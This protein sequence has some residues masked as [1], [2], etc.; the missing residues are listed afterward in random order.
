MYECPNCGG[1]LRFDIAS[2]Q[3]ACA[4]CDAKYDPYVITKDRDAEESRDFEVT[5]FTC[6]QC[7]GE[8]YSTDNTAAG[9]CSFCGASTILDSRL[10]RQKRPG[11]IIPFKKTKA[12]CKR[13][14]AKIVK[15]A[16]FAPK[17]LRDEK[18]IDSFRGIYMPYWV[19][20]ITQKGPFHMTG[21][22]SHQSGDYYITDYYNISGKL[23]TYYKGLYYDASSSFADNISERI[24]PFDV[25]NMRG[26]TPSILSGF[27]ADTADVDQALYKEDA[28]EKANGQTKKYIDRSKEMKGYSLDKYSDLSSKY[29]TRCESADIAMF[30]VWFLSYR[31]KDRVAYATVNGQTG[32]VVADLP[33]DIKK[34]MGGSFLLAVIIFL[35]LN[36]FATFR[37]STTLMF[38]AGIAVMALILHKIEMKQ[39]IEKEQYLD[40]KGAMNAL[41]RR[42]EKEQD[43]QQAEVAGT[44]DEYTYWNNA[45]KSKTNQKIQAGQKSPKKKS[46]SS[47]V[48]TVIMIAIVVDAI[49]NL[50][51]VSVA[52]GGTGNVLGGIVVLPVGI[53]AGVINFVGYQRMEGMSKVPGFLGAFISVL[54]ACVV[55]IWNPVSDLYYYAGAIISLVAVFFTLVNLIR[56]YNILATRKLPQFDYQGGDDRA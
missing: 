46:T 7:A 41:Q 3:L 26:F 53:V 28:I 5:V 44:T 16:I 24:A 34:Y 9:F 35:L 39:I 50:L 49:F 42:T 18:H 8:I 22:M 14:Y 38:V 29:H 56:S 48:L 19:Y 55:L 32:K 25:K 20:Y 4:H 15:K 21:T 36:L 10:T 17:E 37:P 40:D 47:K 33:V 52:A 45:Q 2:Q 11:F 23:D 1:N 12:D 54:L 27:Y 13:E 43:I 51:L 31:N 6:P 30:P